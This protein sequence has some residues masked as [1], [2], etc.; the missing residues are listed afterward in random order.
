VTRRDFSELTRTRRRLSLVAWLALG[1]LDTEH[2]GN[3]P[4]SLGALLVAVSTAV[5][6]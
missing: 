6:Y 2:P 3:T 5:T 1:P 4:A